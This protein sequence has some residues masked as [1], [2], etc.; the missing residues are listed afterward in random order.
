MLLTL[1]IVMVE[2]VLMHGNVRYIILVDVIQMF[3]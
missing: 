3:F 1:R 2:L